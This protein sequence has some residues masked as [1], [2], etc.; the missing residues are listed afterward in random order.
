MSRTLLS[1]V[2]LSVTVGTGQL[3]RGDCPV[4]QEGWLIV[5]AEGDCGWNR[6]DMRPNGNL[7]FAVVPEGS[8]RG[9][10]VLTTTSTSSDKATLD[11]RSLPFGVVGTTSPFAAGTRFRYQWYRVG[12]STVATAALKLGVDNPSVPNQ[13]HSNPTIEQ[14]A[15]EIAFD[16][17][18]VYEPYHQKRTLDLGNMWSET[19]TMETI[20]LEDGLFWVVNLNSA[21]PLPFGH[22]TASMNTGSDGQPRQSTLK[23]LAEWADELSDAG[24]TSPVIRSVQLGVGSANPNVNAAV[25]FLEFES[26]N[27]SYRW[28]FASTTNG[29]TTTTAPPDGIDLIDG[30][31]DA[32]SLPF[33]GGSVDPKKVVAIAPQEVEG[34]TLEAKRG[35]LD[36]IADEIDQAR[37]RAE[38]QPGAAAVRLRWVLD[39]ILGDPAD[40]NDD[41]VVGGLGETIRGLVDEAKRALKP[42]L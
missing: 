10:L 33:A 32:L 23:T 35:T 1:I 36:A 25:D 9:A 3:A 42:G 29:V 27:T 34:D 24:L 17:I 13:G 28:E 11:N 41:L 18:F 26:G 5:D 38:R 7:G 22:G 31:L 12:N 14:G 2:C 19:Q 4:S 15:L 21:S 30:S 20:T 16:L 40:P 37:I 6:G 8:N 39:F